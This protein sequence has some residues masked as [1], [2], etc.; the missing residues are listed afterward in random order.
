M[1][2]QLL[3]VGLLALPLT[4]LARVDSQPCDVNDDFTSKTIFRDNPQFSNGRPEF[5]SLYRF[6]RALLKK[7]GIWGSFQAV[8]FGGK[9]GSSAELARW[10]FPF[11]KT[12]LVV[13]EAPSVNDETGGSI[14]GG[15]DA[16][17]NN[18]Q[19][20]LANN[21]FIN[22]VNHD[23]QS[24]ICICP[25]QEYAGGGFN[26]HQ[27]FT[28][29]EEKGYWFDITVPVV[30]VKQRMNM[31]ETI[32]N[33]GVTL[34][35]SPRSM[36]EAFMSSNL[37]FGKIC[38][39]ELKQTAVSD[40]EM[41][42][43]RDGARGDH[44]HYTGFIGI[45]IPTSNK[46]TAKFL[47]EPIVGRAGHF[48]I[49]WGSNAGYEM[50]RNEDFSV[51][52]NCD[53]NNTWLFA[54]DELRSFDLVDK[55]WS[56]YIRVFTDSTATVSTSGVNIFT[57]CMEIRPKGTWQVNSSFLL[58]YGK[59]EAEA[60]FNLYVRQSEAGKL[61]QPWTSNAGIA[62]T[63]AGHTMSLANMRM[64]DNGLITD[65]VDQSQ[66][67]A[68]PSNN[69]DFVFRTIKASDLNLQSA[70]HPA[71]VAQTIYATVGYNN[72]AATCPGF[73]GFGASYQ[74]SH[75]NAAMNRWTV[76]GKIGVSV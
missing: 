10:F 41:R 37:K 47:F 34:D 22:T 75:N 3:L 20:I 15:S 44:C 70:L 27:V 39:G 6:D 74:F 72:E 46:P 69:V 14:N 62:G 1:N 54:A 48:G 73:A 42:I 58:K 30:Q 18:T 17:K 61:T 32:I 59:F 65:D 21:F 19:D 8:A 68:D 24:N 64:W 5:L 16:F 56:R 26:Y 66:L 31:S 12:C 7:E 25:E 51:I 50:W 40:V 29:D 60:G 36:T 67:F 45:V 4:S 35:G 23:F 2:K 71:C 76:W 38:P 52:A 43:G 57:K 55:Q 11:R 13:G 53:I 49:E 28:D 9:S 63:T 33:Q